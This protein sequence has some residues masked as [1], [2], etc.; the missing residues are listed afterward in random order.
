LY[1]TIYPVYQRGGL[2]DES[3]EG[4]MAKR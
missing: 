1:N 3:T 4:I 2:L